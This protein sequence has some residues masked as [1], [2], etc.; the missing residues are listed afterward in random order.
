MKAK[1]VLYAILFIGNV[2]LAQADTLVLQP[3][4]PEGRDVLISSLQPTL[5]VGGHPDFNALAWTNNGSPVVF[6]SLLDFDF[7]VIPQN[8]TILSAT[9]YLYNNPTSLNNN[10]SHSS[11]SGSNESVLQR[12]TSSWDES[13]VTWDNQLGT[14]TLNQVLLPASNTTDQNYILNITSLV[15]DARDNP[16]QSHGL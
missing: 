12:I 11:L 3:N 13:T 4:V 1:T 2:S 10:G 6:R 15:Q 16:D 14:T 9:L 5:N 7:S 8:S